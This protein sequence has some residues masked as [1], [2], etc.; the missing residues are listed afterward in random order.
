VQ[1]W[2]GAGVRQDRA[3]YHLV[4]S[5]EQ[6]S[7]TLPKGAVE[8]LQIKVNGEDF[9]AEPDAKGRYSVSLP[10]QQSSHQ[11][12][13]TYQMAGADVDS[14]SLE[15][16]LPKFEGNV[17][18]H[19]L[20]WHLA[21]PASRHLIDAPARITPE[22]T[23]VWNG[24]GWDRR[25]SMEHREL[26]SWTG[27]SLGAP[28]PESTNRYLFS[29]AGNPDPIEILTAKRGELVFVTSLTV[30]ALGLMLIQFQILRRPIALLAI[31]VLIAALAAWRAES[32]LLFVQAAL[33]GLALVLLAA[34]IEFT[35]TRRRASPQIVRS[36]GSSI[37]DSRPAPASV[38]TAEPIAPASTESLP[39]EMEVPAAESSSR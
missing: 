34:L 20:Y 33:L 22:F 17:G 36:G 14:H 37:I 39:V 7:F 6:I 11:L 1:T 30:L 35:Q 12:V 2:I 24:I 13:V 25:S 15:V 18:V 10:P 5:E 31:G 38:R 32:A 9:T 3:A 19:H 4:S 16:E 28:L 23:W 21:M 27:I 8:H 26:E 29:L